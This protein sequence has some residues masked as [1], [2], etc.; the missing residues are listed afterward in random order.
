LVIRL[1]EGEEEERELSPD[2]FLNEKKDIASR[3]AATIVL[4]TL[5]IMA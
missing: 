1:K 4:T 3:G 5:G 2:T